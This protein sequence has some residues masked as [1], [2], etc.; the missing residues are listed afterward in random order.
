[1]I[2]L[3]L[4]IETLPGEESL[5]DDIAAEVKPPANITKTETLKKWE[6]EQKLA[7]V[8]EEYRKTALGGGFRVE[9][10]V[11]V[12]SG[13]AATEIRKGSSLAMSAIS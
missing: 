11:S 4:D 12:I 5:R 8:E 2:K 3:F 7:K 10:S 6:E 13:R 1:M 9:F